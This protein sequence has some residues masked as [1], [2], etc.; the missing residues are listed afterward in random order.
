MKKPVKQGKT[1]YR[2]F[3]D[4]VELN[5]WRGGEPVCIDI[6][7]Q[8][9]IGSDVVGGFKIKSNEI[10]DLASGQ[11]DPSGTQGS[12]KTAGNTNIKGAH[13]FKMKNPDGDVV[14][15]FHCNL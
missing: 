14:G 10:L 2:V 12:M 1:H 11:V 13:S 8:D 7:E 15:T 3:F 5:V 4:R 6:M 9:F